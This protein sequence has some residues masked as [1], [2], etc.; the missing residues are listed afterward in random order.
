MRSVMEALGVADAVQAV[1]E[2]RA[3]TKVRAAYATR[4]KA[5]A[6]PTGVR[7]QRKDGDVLDIFDDG[8]QRHAWKRKPGLSGR[9]FRK[10]RKLVNRNLR[11]Q[12]T[13]GTP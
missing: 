4:D 5:H 13:K 1:Q 9:Q 6:K 7:L 8:S 3:I 2:K 10:L 11:R 12:V